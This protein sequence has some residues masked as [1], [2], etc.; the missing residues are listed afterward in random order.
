[1]PKKIYGK[2]KDGLE[3]TDKLIEQYLAEAEKGYDLD[4]LVARRG[5]P[6]LGRAPATTFAVRLDPDLRA[7]LDARAERDGVSAA[8]VLRRALRLFLSTS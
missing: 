8:E 2:T 4:K 3:I 5:R 1:M 6:L 7:A